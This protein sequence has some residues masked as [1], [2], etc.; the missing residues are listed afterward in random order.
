VTYPTHQALNAYTGFLLRKV[1]SA[2]F[3]RF[4]EVV[5]KH[6]LHPMHLGILTIIDAEEPVSQQ[7]LSRRSG[8]DP[9]TMVAR[10][11]VLVERGL[12][13]RGRRAHDRRTYEIRLTA[14]GRRMLHELRQEA[15]AHAER[16]FAPLSETERRQLHAILEKLAASLDEPVAGEPEDDA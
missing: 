1:S 15:R 4:A 14:D 9:S 13:E 2:S 8:V 6:G 16:F 12:V 7:E 3:Q 5:G 10:M 11:D